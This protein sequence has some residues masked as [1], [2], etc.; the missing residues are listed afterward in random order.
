MGKPKI[1]AAVGD[2][3]GLLKVELVVKGG[4][5]RNI[6]EEG[7]KVEEVKDEKKP[8]KKE[9]KKAK[10]ASEDKIKPT[11]VAVGETVRLP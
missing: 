11:Y 10:K 5:K 6:V 2:I 1:Q 8:I 4:P 7:E 3:G 9:G